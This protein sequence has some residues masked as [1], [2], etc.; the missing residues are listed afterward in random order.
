MSNEFPIV[1]KIK[2]SPA[3][4]ALEICL[5]M[6]SQNSD[7]TELKDLHGFYRANP[8]DLVIRVPSGSYRIYG[9]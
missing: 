8:F 1:L 5:K 7:D 3:A 2:F 4:S 9:T 6:K